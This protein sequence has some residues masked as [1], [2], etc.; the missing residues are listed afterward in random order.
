MEVF[1]VGERERLLPTG[2]R[3]RPFCSLEMRASFIGLS[4][5]ERLMSRSC[6]VGLPFLFSDRFRRYDF[7]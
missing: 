4:D 1:R 5:L 2:D 3:E 7:R 6:F